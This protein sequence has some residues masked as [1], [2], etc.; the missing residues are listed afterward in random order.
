MSNHSIPNKTIIIGAG[1]HAKVIIDMLRTDPNVEVIGCIG[2][3]PHGTVLDIPII[4][5][6][7]ALPLLFEQGIRH[8]FVAIGNNSKRRILAMHAKSLGF[9]LINAVSP[10]SYIAPSVS[11]GQGIAVMA[12]AIIQA[13]SR[14]GS[15]SIINTGATVDHDAMIGESCHIAPGCTLSGCVTVGAESFLGTGVKVID[16][17]HIGASCMVGAGAVVIR[18]LPDAVLALGVPAIVKRKLP[19]KEG[20]QY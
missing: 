16:G 9:E 4:G 13:D 20:M 8:A 17:T 2:H 10:R 18:N 3:Q 6:D 15:Y 14:I 12:G 19:M 1:G 5:G 11:L 7:E